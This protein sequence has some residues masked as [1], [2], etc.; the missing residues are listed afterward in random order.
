MAD[1]LERRPGANGPGYGGP[2]RGLRSF[3]QGNTAAVRHGAYAVTSLTGRARDVA[4][5]LEQLMRA[6]ELFRPAFSPTIAAAS[7]VIVRLERAEAA[8]SK[9]DEAA[10]DNA[11]GPY[12]GEHGDAI[13]R[14][15]QDARGWANSA[16]RYFDALGLSPASLARIARDTGVG[17]AARASAALRALEEHVGREYG[18]ERGAAE[19]DS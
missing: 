6:E 19:G 16:L 1:E 12:V 8:L 7:V 9:V 2:A 5:A 11:L 13:A 3:E 15:R 4:H 17:K 14:L 10:G 18:A